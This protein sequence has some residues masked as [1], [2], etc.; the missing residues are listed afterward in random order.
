[1][2][3]KIYLLIF[4]FFNAASL[5]AS[6]LDITTITKG[7]GSTA[8]Q[9]LQNAVSN[10]LTQAVG[11]YMDVD[12]Q[13]NKRTEIEIETQKLTNNL[14]ELLSEKKTFTKE[15]TNKINEYSNGVINSVEVLD[16]KQENGL[17]ITTA[18]VVIRDD[19]LKIR[20]AAIS[21]V[22]A[23]M[24]VGILANI[25]EKKS[26]ANNL[27][28]IL[29]SK[30]ILPLWNGTEASVSVEFIGSIDTDIPTPDY[31]LS[32][33]SKG[34]NGFKLTGSVSR[35]FSNILAI[36]KQDLL[37]KIKTKQSQ[38]AQAAKKRRATT[39]S[40]IVLDVKTTLS[41]GYIQSI[42]KIFEEN[43]KHKISFKTG[44]YSV[45]INFHGTFLHV[46]GGSNALR[47]LD[48]IIKNNN[49]MRTYCIE[50]HYYK[51][52]CYVLDVCR[53]ANKDSQ[54]GELDWFYERHTPCY[55]GGRR[56]EDKTYTTELK[57]FNSAN[58]VLKSENVNQC[59]L[60]TYNK[61]GLTGV[62]SI[63]NPGIRNFM[64]SSNYNTY[65]L[66]KESWDRIYFT[67]SDEILS[68]V[69]NIE[70]SI[71]P[72]KAPWQKRPR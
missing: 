44:C 13:I 59:D 20:F 67:Y 43:A 27:S 40:T 4:L 66:T 54:F 17:F 46:C 37:A 68:E 24:K 71:I 7:Y 26:Q 42:Q 31:Y 56:V 63:K 65:Y 18:K 51:A 45:S 57:L 12:T 6:N 50:E 3:K 69:A 64:K 41:E 10:A 36:S 21:S 15:I 32:N 16:V 47:E 35:A 52:N 29:S 22:K 48:D 28:E 34:S 70:Y 39:D 33:I 19:R 60:D 30:V 11:S 1:M 62:Q 49:A 14:G 5:Q 25:I 38:I 72:P 61:I 8:K 23:P 53:V 58:Q 55:G 9:S 2:I